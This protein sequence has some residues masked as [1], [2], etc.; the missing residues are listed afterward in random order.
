VVF[1]GIGCVITLLLFGCGDDSPREPRVIPGDRTTP[2]PT[3]RDRSRGSS[4]DCEVPTCSGSECCEDDRECERKCRDLDIASGDCDDL[5][6]KTVEAIDDLFGDGR[7]SEFD[8]PN[9]DDLEDL[10]TDDYTNIC[11]A[12]NLDK[13]EAD[14]W[15]EAIKEHRYSSSDAEAVMKWFIEQDLATEILDRTA[16]DTKEVILNRLLFIMGGG[17]HSGSISGSDGARDIIEGLEEEID[18]DDDAGVMYYAHRKSNTK[19]IDIIH[20]CVVKDELCDSS[21]NHPVP[22][23]GASGYS[24]SSLADARKKS[25]EACQLA[26]YCKSITD[27]N[28]RKDVAGDVED[29][30]IKNFIEDEVNDGGLGIDDDP[31]DWTDEACEELEDRWNNPTSGLDLG[32]GS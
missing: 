3:D 32:L 14:V 19:M 5:P 30:G 23:S 1:S 2:P 26:V 15:E 18:S 21:T 10:T 27:E 17:S 13:T 7:K 24:T 11:I 31:E 9:D 22:V 28:H 12:T 8:S 20:E 4:L 25:E 6:I 29:N 16:N